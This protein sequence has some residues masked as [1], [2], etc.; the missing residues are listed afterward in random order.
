M[1]SYAKI[2]NDREDASGDLVARGHLV[3]RVKNV[4]RACEIFKIAIR[5]RVFWGSLKS[6]EYHW[7]LVI[8]H[9]HITVKERFYYFILYLTPSMSATARLLQS[10]QLSGNNFQIIEQWQ[11]LSLRI[12]YVPITWKYIFLRDIA[13]PCIGHVKVHLIFID[14]DIEHC[15]GCSNSL[16]KRS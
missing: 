2:R 10:G 14:I 5:L 4:C 3:A 7:K 16:N 13:L 1:V 12:Y 9:Y 15:P 6:R 11:A 8:P